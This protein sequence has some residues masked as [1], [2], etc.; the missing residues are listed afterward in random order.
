M[1]VQGLLHSQG[2]FCICR[3]KAIILDGMKKIPLFIAFYWSAVGTAQMSDRQ[4][5]V[6]QMD[7]MV[8]PVLRSLAHDSLRINMP[9][10]VSVRIDDAESRRKVAYLEILGRTL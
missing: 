2:A 8:R 5:W 6:A 9:T 1:R 7:K 3:Q 10:T 4:F